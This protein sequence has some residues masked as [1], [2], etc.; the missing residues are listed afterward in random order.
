M[1][2]ILWS[3]FFL[4]KTVIFLF[5]QVCLRRSYDGEAGSP[6]TS[7]TKA[8]GHLLYVL[9]LYTCG[10]GTE[11]IR[12]QKLRGV[13]QCFV[14]IESI[15]SPLWIVRSY[16]SFFDPP[17]FCCSPQATD[18]SWPHLARCISQK[19]RRKMLFPPTAA[20]QSTSTVERLAKATE[21]GSQFWVGNKLL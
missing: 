4:L 6:N 2:H 1:I 13:P 15:G 19:C 18:S 14:H 11:N 8:L 20:S 9:I 3:A 16:R 7:W 17:L 10:S 12:F 5:E 21:P